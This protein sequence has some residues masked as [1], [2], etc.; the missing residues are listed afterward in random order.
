M[1]QTQIWHESALWEHDEDE[2]IHATYFVDTSFRTAEE[3]H[4]VFQAIAD[5]ELWDVVLTTPS[6][7]WRYHPYDGGADIVTTNA[8]TR[9]ALLNRHRAWLSARADGM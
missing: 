6:V 9:D 5:E 8:A 1:P 2:D 3:L 4:S 7:S